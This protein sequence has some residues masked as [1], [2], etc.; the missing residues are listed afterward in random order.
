[1]INLKEAKEVTNF[2]KEK[3]YKGLSF[4]ED[5]LI[6]MTDWIEKTIQVLHLHKMICGKALHKNKTYDIH[7]KLVDD[8]I[9]EVEL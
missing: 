3:E 2:W 7:M 4:A 6:S 5:N 9:A 8:L 1:M